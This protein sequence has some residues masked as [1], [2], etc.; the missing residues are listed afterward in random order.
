MTKYILWINSVV[1]AAVV[2]KK[3]NFVHKPDAPL[4]NCRMLLFFHLNF[5]T[6]LLDLVPCLVFLTSFQNAYK[7]QRL[8]NNSFLNENF[9]NMWFLFQAMREVIF[10]KNFITRKNELKTV[11]LECFIWITSSKN[12]HPFW[13][14]LIIIKIWHK[15]LNTTWNDYKILC[16]TLDLFKFIFFNDNEKLKIIRYE[17]NLILKYLIYFLFY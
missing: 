12:I 7:F 11:F 13:K 6:F 2:Y 3:K 16:L 4:V 5:F 17:F 15:L 8:F 9:Y 14:V 10:R 1:S